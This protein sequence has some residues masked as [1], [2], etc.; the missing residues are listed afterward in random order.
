VILP[1]SR[2]QRV[3][4][5]ALLV[6]PLLLIVVLSAPAWAAWPFLSGPRRDAVL[7]FLGCLIDWVNAIP[8]PGPTEPA[9]NTNPV[10]RRSGTLPQSGPYGPLTPGPRPEPYSA[11]HRTPG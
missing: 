10:P 2:W 3:A 1:S 6:L 9:L 11:R 4:V 7:Q 5:T 8:G